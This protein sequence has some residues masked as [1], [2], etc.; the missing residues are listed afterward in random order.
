M[1]S[2]STPSL[3]APYVSC[4][5]WQSRVSG[6]LGGIRRS[7]VTVKQI[8]ARIEPPIHSPTKSNSTTFVCFRCFISKRR[9][10]ER[11]FIAVQELCKLKIAPY[12]NNA[13][14]QKGYLGGSTG[15]WAVSAYSGRVHRYF[16]N[17]FHIL[18]L[19]NIHSH[20][21]RPASVAAE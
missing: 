3:S 21:R 2:C 16:L 11:P 4:R 1:R 14:R 12:L 8:Y 19:L 20:D 13:A 7:C 15:H 6:C 18:A 9:P 5:H 17:A 10:A